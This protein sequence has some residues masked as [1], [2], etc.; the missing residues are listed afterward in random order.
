M[1]LTI[2]LTFILIIVDNMFGNTRP[3]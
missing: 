2:L 1:I 3:I